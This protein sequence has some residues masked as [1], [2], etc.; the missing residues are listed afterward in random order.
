MKI[1][2]LIAGVV[3][4][5]VVLAT[6]LAPAGH[7]SACD[8]PDCYYKKVIVTV[9][10][11]EP[12]QVCVTKYDHCGT[13]YHVYLTKYRTVEVPVVKWVKICL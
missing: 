7:V 12:Y 6:L 2:K 3:S 9:C 11:Q 13:P 8:T 10:H 1:S 4:T 5:L